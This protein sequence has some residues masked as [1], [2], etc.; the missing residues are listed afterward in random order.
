[1]K[2]TYMTPGV[3]IQDTD[4]IGSVIAAPTSEMVFVGLFLKGPD[5]SD[6]QPFLVKSFAEFEQQFGGIWEKS[7]ASYAIHQFFLNGGNQCSVIRIMPD[8]DSGNESEGS[9]PKAAAVL[10]DAAKKTGLQALEAA[11]SFN[12]LAI[13]L[14]RRFEKD[15]S[16]YATIV[17]AATAL[18]EK[19]LA[20]LFGIFPVT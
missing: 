10:G 5:D 4:H 13:P 18:C 7:E 8:A 1:M 9:L 11:S 2:K 19:K 6:S 15:S 3:Y 16:N 12:L 20:F 14:L 17:K